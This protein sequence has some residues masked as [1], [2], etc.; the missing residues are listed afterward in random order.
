MSNVTNI[1]VWIKYIQSKHLCQHIK[2]K[3]INMFTLGLN[4]IDTGMF[5]SVFSDYD[6]TRRR[7]LGSLDGSGTERLAN[8]G[9]GEEKQ[10]PILHVPGWAYV[11]VVLN[12][13]RTRSAIQRASPGVAGVIGG[14]LL[15]IIAKPMEAAGP[16][17]RARTARL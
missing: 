4:I 5:I 2:G 14:S 13:A 3:S 15:K 6:T 8:S 1:N 9:S 17:A 11:G 12:G 10:Q 16:P 7:G